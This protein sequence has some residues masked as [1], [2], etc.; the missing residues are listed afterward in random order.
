MGKRNDSQTIRCEHFTWKM[1]RRGT[2]FYAD[3]RAGAT[4]LGKHSL[5]A[6]TEEEAIKNLQRLDRVKARERGLINDEG[7]LSSAA[8][9]PEP[10]PVSIGVGWA[11]FLERFDN[12]VVMGSRSEN[13]LIRYRE[14]RQK[15]IEFCQSQRIQSWTGFTEEQAERYI[16]WLIE[17]HK[18]APRS[19][20]LA[21]TTVLSVM[22]FLIRRKALDAA[23]RIYIPVPKL[24]GSDT[25]CYER[26]EVARMLEFCQQSSS[27]RWLRP[28]LLTL[29]TTGMRIGELRNL[30]WRDI[31]FHANAI[32][33]R[34]ERSSRRKGGDGL[35][36]RTTKGKRDRTIPLNHK[37]KAVLEKLREEKH[38][39]GFIFHGPK[40][41]RINSK[42]FLVIFRR[43]VLNKLKNEF[44]T[45]NS[46]TGFEHG[47][48]HGFRHYFVSEAFLMNF[49]ET[50]IMDWVGHRSSAMVHHYRHNRPG[51]S[52]QR[53]CSMDFISD[54]TVSSGN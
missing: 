11:K 23:Y 2:I 20:D 4:N 22:K 46:D 32:H 35:E 34:D 36:K 17:E 7:P 8:P 15:H 30:R 13:T 14:I 47:T 43:R 10:E 12:L 3:G 1:F 37:L 27:T 52:Q 16:R 25:Y 28:I 42:Q 24:Q 53:M 48:V 40:G 33:V 39:D 54:D 45:S 6:K 5:S 31:N 19:R 44:P 9:K 51:V 26:R 18:A 49:S 38:S 41:A 21:I 50:E 29:A